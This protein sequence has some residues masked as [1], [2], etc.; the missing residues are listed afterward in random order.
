M[1]TMGRPAQPVPNLVNG[2]PAWAVRSRTP[3][4]PRNSSTPGPSGP[5]VLCFME[6]TAVARRPLQ[7]T[8]GVKRG[9][10]QKITPP[11]TRRRWVASV[12]R[13]W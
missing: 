2:A 11:V 8:A 6:L 1:V 13:A 10:A 4:R 7:R 9:S 12:L 5:G 3:A